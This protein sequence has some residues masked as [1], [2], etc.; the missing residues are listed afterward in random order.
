VH[1]N[2]DGSYLLAEQ[3][4]SSILEALEGQ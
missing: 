3:V 1:F 4:A 2:K